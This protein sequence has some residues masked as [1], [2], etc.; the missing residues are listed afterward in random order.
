MSK[1]LAIFTVALITTFTFH[2][3]NFRISHRFDQSSEAKYPLAEGFQSKPWA[4][5][6]APLWFGI[7]GMIILSTTSSGASGAI[8]LK[9]G[10]S[11]QFL[12][13]NSM[14]NLS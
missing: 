9:T 8:Q 4:F 14:N 12:Q 10:A 5:I 2:Q 6:F 7:M 11:R 13:N 1:C 3:S